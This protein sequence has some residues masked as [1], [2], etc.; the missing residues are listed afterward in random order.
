MCN[1]EIFEKKIKVKFKNQDLLR[2]ALVHRSYINE[3]K[4]F[5]LDHNE[6]LEFLG[7][8]VL[9]LVTTEFLYN[10]FSNPEG[11]LTNFRA[12]LVNRKMLAKISE[13]LGLEEYLLMSKGETK[14]TGRARQYI[15]ANALEAVIGA[16]YLDQGYKKSAKFIAENFL[17]KMDNVLSDKLYQDPKSKF[18]EIAQEIVGVTPVYRVIREW[19]PDHDKHFMIGV[20]LGEEKVAEGEGISKQAAQRKAA[21]KGLKAREWE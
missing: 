4:D 21:E 14:D 15:I 18:Q 8:A 11:E 5:E 3:H 7:D 12:A 10:K 20:F 9:E 1:L 19:G 17:V 6:R 2:Q 13:E 16:I